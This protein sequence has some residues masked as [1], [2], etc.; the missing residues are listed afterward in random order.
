MA[1]NHTSAAV[2]LVLSAILSGCG[3]NGTSS[4]TVDAEQQASI[5][6]MKDQLLK[7]QAKGKRVGTSSPIDQMRA[8]MMR[9]TK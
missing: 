4:A 6:A 3:G 1:R 5:D 9:K 2:G 8:S 7:N